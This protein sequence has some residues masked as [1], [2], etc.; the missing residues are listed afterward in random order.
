MP[1]IRNI[2]VGLPCKDGHVLALEG[3]DSVRDLRFYRA[4]GGGIEFGETAELALRREF[5]EELACEL[6]AALRGAFT[7]LN[8]LVIPHLVRQGFTDLRPA[9]AA[10]FQYLDD[11]GT[12]VSALAQRAQMTKQA[13]A[14]LVAHLEQHGYVT[15]MPDSTDRRAKLVLPTDRGLRVLRA[16]QVL[17][18]EIERRVAD[19]I[20]EDRLQRLRADLDAI[21]A[22]FAITEAD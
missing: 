8:D 1:R 3:Y 14:E 17:V 10:V 9:H 6:G 7:A 22:E 21:R 5:R 18:P 2:A 15:R 12:T 20:G 19:A 4:I 11:T 13:M 16:A